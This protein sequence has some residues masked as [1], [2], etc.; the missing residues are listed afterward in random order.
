MIEVLSVA[1]EVYPLIKTGGLA[2]VAGALPGALSGHSVTMRTLVPGYPAVMA[3]LGRG[4]LV[5][6]LDDLF[7]VPAKLIAA[8]VAGLDVIVIDAPALYD[9]P[10][11]PYVGPEGW[12]WPDNWKRYAAL[13][14]VA[15]ELG[16]G[17]VEGYRPQVIHAHDW[18][19]AMAPAYLRYGGAGI[20]SVVTV[21]N[22]AFQGQFPATIFPELGL[23]PEAMSLDGVEYYGGVGFLKAGLQAADAITTVLN[24]RQNLK[25]YTVLGS[26]GGSRCAR[27]ETRA[28]ESRRCR[29][30]LLKSNG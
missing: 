1:S 15:S 18:Q 17:L 25:Q 7:G 2:D 14:W 20:S 6:E 9:R 10:G 22:L 23:P 30:A 13:S 4:R 5:K 26:G 28:G 27:M 16:L 8:R 29:L 3:K 19:A 24:D 12:D 21:H 11:N